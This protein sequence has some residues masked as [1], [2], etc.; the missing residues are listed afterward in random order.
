MKGCSGGMA[1]HCK[2]PQRHSGAREA[3]RAGALD[4]CRVRKG[5]GTASATC[6]RGPRPDRVR[7]AREDGAPL[8][9][10]RYADALD[11]PFELDAG[12]FAHPR[13]HGL[14]QLLDIGGGGATE[15]DQKVAVQ[16]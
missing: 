11:L 7:T 12:I 3:C 5:A 8:R 4:P 1:W 6:A 14:T 9:T 15:I 16:L 10:L 13:A 2:V